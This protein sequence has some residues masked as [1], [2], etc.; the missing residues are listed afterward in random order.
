MSRISPLFLGLSA[1]CVAAALFQPT[2]ASELDWAYAG[3]HD[4]VPP[5]T[6]EV[7]L[8]SNVNHIRSAREY[9]I[10]TGI[11]KSGS[12]TAL[13]IL[14]EGFEPTFGDTASS[15]IVD[16][17]YIISWAEATGD[18]SA[19]LNSVSDRYFSNEE[20]NK[21]LLDTYLRIDAHWNT[22]AI[23]LET[24]EKRWQVSEPSASMNFVSSKRNHNGV[25]PAAG[26]GVVVT[27]TV[28]GNVFAYDVA[29][30][31]QRWQTTIP[32]WHER[33]SADKAEALETRSIRGG[34][35]D[36]WGSK[37]A[38][39]VVVDDIAVIPD[40]HGGLFA[41]SLDDGS[42]LWHT[43][44]RM[45][46]HMV[47]RVW[48][49]DGHSY[50]LANKASDHRA[51]YRLHL[52]DARSGETLWSHKTGPNPA[53]LTLGEGVVILN[54][55]SN[56]RGDPQLTAYDITLEGLQERWRMD[57]NFAIGTRGSHRRGVIADGVLYQIIG[58]R[59]RHV[60]SFD[61]ETGKELHRLAGKVH[62]NACLPVVHGNMLY[63]Q[64]DKAHSDPSGLHV[65]Q[66][67][68]GGQFG[69]QGDVTYKALGISAITDYEHPIELPYSNGRLVHRG[70]S[71]I[72]AIDLRSVNNAL[73]EA[74]FINAWPGFH[75]PVQALFFAD[76]EGTITSGRMEV[77]PRDELGVVGTSAR[78]SDDWFPIHTSDPMTIG[79]A[80]E[81]TMTM[82][83]DSFSWD[84]AIT[85]EEAE[86]DTWRGTWTRS[87]AGWDETL[88]L[89]GELDHASEGGYSR[90]GWPTGWLED[91]PITFFG[92]L[93]EGQQRV[94]LQFHGALPRE[95]GDHKGITVCIDHD[96]EKVISALAG[97]F[98]FS[99]S[100]HEVDASELQI[101]ADGMTGT[102]T[103]IV[104]GDGWVENPNWVNGGSLLGSLTLDVSF[105][106]ANSDGIYPVR[107]SWAAEWGLGGDR[108]GLIEASIVRP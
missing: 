52:L 95:D 4:F 3:A 78:R 22:L 100:Y 75:R 63:M 72:V 104:N 37:R 62:S 89:D 14:E 21:A 86:G 91:Q 1:V 60:V 106:E 85:M 57:E 15:I 8:T 54:A 45:D 11:G 92:Q 97:G 81:T 59:P 12:G 49:H 24:G 83:M 73:A 6:E 25:S 101:S 82:N 17:L 87:F 18:V 42:Q 50:I 35:N 74:A 80:L 93:E 94:I 88:H 48:E 32:G 33:A 53:Q 66:L 40:L 16:G 30:G 7:H 31:E 44:D 23:D 108:Q 43:E 96:G 105:G 68:D 27:I 28:T 20:R 67:Q 46:D 77:P 56:R 65:F 19:D 90:R 55:N 9:R 64:N 103:I 41:V 79:A 29:S 84:A 51:G 38:G 61:L 102:A 13:G 70:V 76:A 39:A 98:S 26:N 69:Y 34:S 36:I 71:E 99:Q 5:L 58:D 47:P 107:D 10:H 2:A